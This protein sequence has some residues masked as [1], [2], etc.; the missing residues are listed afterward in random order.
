MKTL[1]W[2]DIDKILEGCSM[3]QKVN[4]LQVGWLSASYHNVILS[5]IILDMRDEI[6]RVRNRNNDQAP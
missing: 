4:A 2:D 1:T 3:D 6:N 5:E